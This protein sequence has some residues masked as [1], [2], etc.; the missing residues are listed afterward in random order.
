MLGIEL[1]DS[2]INGEAGREYE[3]GIPELIGY[4]EAIGDLC[5]YGS[6]VATP[7]KTE[8]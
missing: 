8:P 7:D 6:V 1:A 2:D 4:G 5:K 3:D